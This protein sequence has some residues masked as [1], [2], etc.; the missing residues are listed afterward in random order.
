MDGEILVNTFSNAHTHRH[1]QAHPRRR[2]LDVFMLLHES[3]SEM[4]FLPLAPKIFLFTTHNF[5]FSGFDFSS[6]VG[7][8]R[9]KKNSMER[10]GKVEGEEKEI[11]L[12]KLCC[13]RMF[14]SAVDTRDASG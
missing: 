7:F 14:N 10:G 4:C 11:F 13:S 5:T 6:R 9:A 1:G 8:E 12:I 3:R 2:M